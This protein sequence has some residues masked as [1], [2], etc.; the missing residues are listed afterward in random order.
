MTNFTPTYLINTSEDFESWVRKQPF[1]YKAGIIFLNSSEQ[2]FKVLESRQKGFSF[3]L[4]FHPG[5]T[6]NSTIE[7]ND[8]IDV[9][10]IHNTFHSK[11]DFTD[12][13]IP[14]ITRANFLK[15]QKELD[16]SA[17]HF[18]H[19]GYR[20]YY[21][22]YCSTDEFINDIPVFQKEH[23]SE[24]SKSVISE[25]LFDSSIQEEIVPKITILTALTNDE[26][27]SFRENT[28]KI[29][30]KAGVLK[31]KFK[32]DDSFSFDYEYPLF[33]ERQNNRMG[34]V[35]SS[36][37]TSKIYKN[38]TNV[39][40]MSGVCGGRKSEGVELYDLII[41]SDVV[42]IITGKYEG[43]TFVPIGYQEPTNEQLIDHLSESQRLNEIKN[44]MYSLIPNNKN[45]KRLNEI[46]NNLNIKIGVMACGPF[47]L[48]SGEFLEIKSKEINDKIIGFEMESYGVMRAT[49]FI[50]N[51]NNLSLVVKSVMDFT[52]EHK[53]DSVIGEPVKSIA[54]YI[55]Y[56]CVRVLIPYIDKF[57]KENI[58]K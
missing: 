14:L 3:R 48:K 19:L 16:K 32:P 20:F 46:I 53:S 38:G 57:Y 18:N 39:L 4:L 5:L 12:I 35:E 58:L 55:S 8:L 31:A 6:G 49:K 21:A 2:F 52:D 33:F 22:P 1:Y 10:A 27:S 9:E 51:P 23:I 15:R 7:E 42:D 30:E 37:T 11:P 13:K 44:R 26:Y 34:S 56:L 17:I 47:V 45:S 41:A 36:I 28:N 40:I 43:N 29:E 50:N 54:A 25:A 24:N